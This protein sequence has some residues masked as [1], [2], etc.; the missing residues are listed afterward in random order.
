VTI[1]QGEQDLMVPFAHGQWLVAH[2]PGADAE[3]SKED[4][5]LSIAVGRFDEILDGLSAQANSS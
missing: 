2:I 1:W 5:H 4:G 3:L